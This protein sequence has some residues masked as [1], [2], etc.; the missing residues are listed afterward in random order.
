MYFAL[1][2]SIANIFA[3]YV[4]MF[5]HLGLPEMGAVGT[6]Y[7]TALVMWIMFLCMVLFS[8]RQEARRE[9]NI[10]TGL[11][12][13]TR[14]FLKET[15]R[16]G[17]PNG[18]SLGIEVT[19]FAVAAL[20]IGSMGM[21]PV[22]AH[23]VTINVAALTFMVPLGLSFAISA[24]V[25]FSVGQN[26]IAGARFIG[27]IGIGLSA[28]F[29]GI[30]AIL[31]FTFP[32]QIIWIYTRDPAV[33]EIAVTL[34]FFAAV[35]QISDGLQVSGLGALRGLKDTKIPMIVN[36]IAYWIIGLPSGYLLGVYYGQ[37]PA[38]LWI[39]L[40][41]GLSVAAVLH[42][43]RFNALTRRITS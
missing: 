38:G 31:M 4:F 28:F 17:V 26:D 33:T 37:G 35:F 42:N 16:I 39:G 5:G 15:L 24:R 9:Y 3:D 12:W 1:V 7:A 18:F 43:I 25:G 21:N 20:I 34:L 30:A 10:I 23:Q 36:L 11:S 2:G 13:P 22:A 19:M 27:H 41:I 32:E 29:M 6:G 8:F 40:I 14:T